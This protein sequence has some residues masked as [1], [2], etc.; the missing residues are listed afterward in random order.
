MG[1]DGNEKKIQLTIVVMG[2]PTKV[3]A[4]VNA[5]LRSVA[6]KA[7]EQTHQTE[8]DMSRWEMTTAAGTELKL[9]TKVGDAGLKDEETIHLNLRTGITG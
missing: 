4:N 8:Q 7:I 1:K 6:G 5:P 9:G 2:T 3:D